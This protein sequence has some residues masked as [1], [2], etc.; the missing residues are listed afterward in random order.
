[1]RA[2]KPPFCNALFVDFLYL[3]RDYG[4][5]CGPRELLELNEGLEKGIVH[6]LDDLFVFM[7]LV[8]VKKVEH[9][10]AYERAFALYFFDVDIPAV[11][12]GDPELF[13]TKQFRKWLEKQIRDGNIAQK[14]WWS[15]DHEELMRKFWETVRE[16]MEEHHGGSRWI[17]TGGNSPWG[18]SGNAERGIRVHGESRNR[19]ALKVIGD[20]RYIEYSERNMLREENLRQALESMKHMKN[21]GPRDRLN[22]DETIY[23]TAKNGG[24]IELIFERDLRDRISVVLLIDNGGYSMRPFID[25]TRLLFAKLHARFEDLETYFFHNTIYEKVWSD[26]QHTRPVE[27]EQLLQRRS[28]LRLVILGDAAMAP[29]ELEMRG[30]AITNWYGTDAPP[31]TYWL[32]RLADRFPHS[33]WLNPI[34]REHWDE[35]H[36]RY[37]L[38][39]VRG[40][41]HM[42]D[43]TLGGIHG[44]VEHLSEKTPSG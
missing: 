15:Y 30:G 11:A 43:M 33:C 40:F 2:Q 9:M 38:N 1:M 35:A 18:H 41:F 25:I 4:V 34:P 23:R 27:T 8:F 39:R 5:P 36:G 20:R 26:Y 17:G 32:K 22:L 12:E 10:D 16:Q 29:E 19:S 42:E 21:E 13:N 28:D 31:S 37:T 14:A 7:R 44:M 3:L 6:T 24:E